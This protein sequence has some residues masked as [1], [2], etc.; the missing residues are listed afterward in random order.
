MNKQLHIVSFD[1]PYPPDYG[2]V[3]DVLNKIRNLKKAGVAITLHCFEYGRG[4]QL[5]LEK[6]CDKVFYYPRKKMPSFRL[7][8]II[9]S[10]RNKKL[11]ERLLLAGGP[12]LLEGVHCTYYL[13]TGDL[14]NENI[15]VR[16]HNVEYNYY[17]QLYK[18]AR[19]IFYKTY[20]YFESKLLRNY[21]K[22]LAKGNQFIALSIKDRIAYQAMGAA[23]TQYIPLFGNPDKINCKP[24]KGKYCLYH[25]NLSVSEN[26]EVAVF[27]IEQVFS[28]LD[29]PLIISGKDPSER[30]RKITVRHKVEL[31]ENPDET[32]LYTLM[33]DA[34]I[35]VLP[36]FNQ[37]GMKVKILHALSNGKFVLTNDSAVQ[38][39]E[40]ASLCMIANDAD[41]MVRSIQQL[42]TLTFTQENIAERE[43]VMNEIFNAEKNTE[44]L[45]RILFS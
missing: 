41:A 30:L 42:M 34:H 3:I 11:K 14:K 43:T 24:G 21:E 28:A 10:R 33:S 26:E 32:Q 8:F 5:E 35:H 2:G 31:I 45:I 16:L 15:W 6:Y 20:Y 17:Y 18:S 12:I 19:R 40:W 39:E 36:S 4:R 9:V 1:V 22:K 37:T 44:K 13:Y 27:L 7:P 38:H 25:G 29:V 23:A